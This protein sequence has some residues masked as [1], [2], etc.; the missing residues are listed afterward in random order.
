MPHRA[1]ESE[2]GEEISL[3][4]IYAQLKVVQNEITNMKSDINNKHLENRADYNRL[5]M[6]VTDLDKALWRVK[7]KIA[8]Y[9]ALGSLFGGVVTSLIVKGIQSAMH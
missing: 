9:S 7:I 2:N 8:T 1:L 5:D 6:R 4:Q 3:V